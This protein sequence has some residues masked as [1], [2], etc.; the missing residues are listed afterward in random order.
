MITCK[1][2]HTWLSEDDRGFEM[3]RGGHVSAQLLHPLVLGSTQRRLQRFDFLAQQN[4]LPKNFLWLG[5]PGQITFLHTVT[6]EKKQGTAGVL[7][8]AFWGRA[9]FSQWVIV[10]PQNF[11]QGSQGLFCAENKDTKERVTGRKLGWERPCGEVE[12][13]MESGNTS[14]P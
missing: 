5:D 9:I 2:H 1:S 3:S 6:H 11:D 12:S 13:G 8:E 4:P 14:W 7:R 10:Y